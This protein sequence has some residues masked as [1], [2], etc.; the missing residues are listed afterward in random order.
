MKRLGKPSWILF[1]RG[2]LLVLFVVLFVQA[3][4]IVHRIICV[5]CFVT[6]LAVL[7]YDLLKIRRGEGTYEDLRG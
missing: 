7:I 6:I 3:Q 2:L 4:L 5:I 1:E